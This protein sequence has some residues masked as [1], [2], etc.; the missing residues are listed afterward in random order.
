MCERCHNSNHPAYS[1]YGGRG[2]TMCDEWRESFLTFLE[3]MG[4]KPDGL[5]LERRDN[6]RGYSSENCYWATRKQQREN[7]RILVHLSD[8]PMSNIQLDKRKNNRWQVRM[9]VKTKMTSKQIRKT[10]DSVEKAKEF[11]DAIIYEKMFHR[12][13]GLM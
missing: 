6:N 12:Q 1:N 10:F 13:L 11:R 8:D 5:T 3:D 4:H 7:Q 9:R 2:I